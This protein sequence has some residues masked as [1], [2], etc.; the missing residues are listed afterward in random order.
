[1]DPKK[2]TQEPVEKQYTAEELKKMREGIKH[3]Y[4]Q[5]ISVLKLQHEHARL[6]A[7]LKEFHVRELKATY[8]EASIFDSMQRAQEKNQEKTPPSES[9]PKGPFIPKGES[10]PES[11]LEKP[12]DV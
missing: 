7:E 12:T 3:N 9:K 4:K 8:E 2:P 1:M 10:K 6:K 11:K 5:E